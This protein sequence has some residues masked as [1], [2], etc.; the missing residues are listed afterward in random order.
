MMRAMTQNARPDSPRVR[1]HEVAGE[2]AGQRLDNF[3]LRILKGAPKSMIYRIIRKGEVRINKGRTKPDYR[4]RAGDQVRI[5]PVRVA[6]DKPGPSSG[7]VDFL[8]DRILF[9]DNR[10]LILDKPSGMAVHGGSGLAYGVIEGLRA[11][12]PTAPFLEL[13]H[14]LDRDTSGCLIIA[15]RRSAL[16]GLHELLREGQVGKIY[17]CLVM[18][19]WQGGAR[20]VDAPLRKFQTGSGERVVRVSP[21]GKPAR[22]YFRP[23]ERYNGATLMEVKLDTGRT[24]QIRVHAASVGHPLAGDDKYGDDAFNNR[25]K[26]LGLRRL[27]LH[28]HRLTF[29]EPGSE[30]DIDVSA[31]L[32]DT[33]ATVLTRLHDNKT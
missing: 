27:F 14:R 22:S 26:G 10:I 19:E 3:L 4:L 32:D 25:M 17:L 16:R 20:W 8:N 30:Q 21:D 5:P 33:L 7:S 9:E 1:M 18:G 29:I 11:L 28:A 15:K 13:V 12:R 31:P 23:I 6:D 24:H 2:E